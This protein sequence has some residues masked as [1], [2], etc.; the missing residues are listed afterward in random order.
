MQALIDNVLFYSVFHTFHRKNNSSV[1][2]RS[3][4]PEG[5]LGSYLCNV[6]LPP[7]MIRCQFLFCGQES[8]HDFSPGE[9]NQCFISFSPVNF[10]NPFLSCVPLSFLPLDYLFLCV[11]RFLISYYSLLLV[12]VMRFRDF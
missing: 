5:P 8:K 9:R 2:L 12:L 3:L 7:L 4:N 10:L 1:I 6:T 11:N